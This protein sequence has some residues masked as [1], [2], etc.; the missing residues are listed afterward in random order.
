M[1]EAAGFQGLNPIKI[2]PADFFLVDTDRVATN[3]YLVKF[4]L[5]A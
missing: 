4:S 5:T 2:P 1:L 3:I